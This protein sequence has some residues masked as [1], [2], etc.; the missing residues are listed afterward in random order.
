[1]LGFVDCNTPLKDCQD[2]IRLATK[3]LTRLPLTA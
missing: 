3:Y 1:M 2:V